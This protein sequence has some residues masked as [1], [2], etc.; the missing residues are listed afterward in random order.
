M[1]AYL[2]LANCPEAGPVL[3][4]NVKVCTGGDLR[5]KE[6]ECLLRACQVMGQNKMSDEKSPPGDAIR[7]SSQVTGL[8]MHF[9]NCGFDYIGI[10]RSV[11][12]G[13]GYI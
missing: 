1:I 5:C 10:V 11:G 12:Q 3:S 7:R 2:H 8:A 4:H 6:A 13:K 9:D